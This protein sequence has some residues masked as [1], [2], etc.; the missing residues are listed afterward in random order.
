LCFTLANPDGSY[1]SHRVF[2]SHSCTLRS[3]RMKRCRRNRLPSGSF[4]RIHLLLISLNGNHR[5]VITMSRSVYKYSASFMDTECRTVGSCAITCTDI[6]GSRPVLIGFVN[7]RFEGIF[8]SYFMVH[9]LTRSVLEGDSAPADFILN[10]V[11]VFRQNL[12]DLTGKSDP[13]DE[14]IRRLMRRSDEVTMFLVVEEQAVRYLT[15]HR[16]HS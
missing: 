14:L 3:M 8:L 4:I 5:K 7:N 6:S 2:H 15:F 16:Q 9:Y 10:A 11:T 1:C 13:L 12:L